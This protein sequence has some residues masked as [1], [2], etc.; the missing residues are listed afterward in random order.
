MAKIGDLDFE[1]FVEAKK[2][3]RVGGGKQQTHNYAYIS[4]QRTRWTFEKFKPV[5]LAVES[6]VRFFKALWRNELLGN[7]VKIG[8]EQFPEVY[9]LT[10]DCAETLGIPVPATYVVS[11]FSLNAATYGTNEESFI[12]LHSALIDHLSKDELKSVIGHECGHIHNKHVVYLTAL[13]YLRSMASSFAGWIVLPAILALQGWSR[14][15]EITSDRAGMLCTK[16]LEVSTRAL[17]KLALGSTKLYEELNLDT[18]LK[19]YDEGQEGV[20]KYFEVFASHPWLTKRVK[21]LRVFAESQIF[22]Q[23]T[24]QSGGLTLE[25]LDEKVHKIIKVVP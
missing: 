10:V 13:H 9:E 19:Q 6:V 8:P 25:E 20:G 1:A 14:R 11:S 5:E 17:A 4:D 7:A 22:K 15:A 24:G 3:S 2:Q 23:H 21:S 12:L 18:F 16:D